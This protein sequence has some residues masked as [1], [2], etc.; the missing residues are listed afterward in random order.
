MFNGNESSKP[1]LAGLNL[2]EG[3]FAGC[4]ADLDFTTMEEILGI[5]MK[6]HVKFMD[7]T[8]WSTFTYSYGKSPFLMGKSTISMVIFNS[9]VSHYQRVMGTRYQVV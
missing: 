4:L 3:I 1:Y 2:L 7:Y 8:L 9:Y 5:P 6:H